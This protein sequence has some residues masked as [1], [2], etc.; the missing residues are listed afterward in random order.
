M[1]FYKTLQTV[2][3]ENDY[4]YVLRKNEKKNMTKIVHLPRACINS[5]ST[6]PL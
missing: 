4:K 1:G 6:I 2:C 5:C 3:P